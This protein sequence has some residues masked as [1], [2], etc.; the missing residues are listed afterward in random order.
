[1]ALITMTHSYQYWVRPK[2]KKG[3]G[4][5]FANVIILLVHPPYTHNKEVKH[6]LLYLYTHKFCLETLTKEKK[7]I[8]TKLLSKL[9]HPKIW[10]TEWKKREERKKDIHHNIEQDTEGRPQCNF[11][12]Q[13]L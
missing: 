13:S 7:E 1:M 6:K 9:W 10:V 4:T 5:V 12:V 8:L 2:R 11:F 3:I